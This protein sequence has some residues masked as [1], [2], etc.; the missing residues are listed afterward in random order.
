MRAPHWI[1]HPPN[2]TSSETDL[3]LQMTLTKEQLCKHIYSCI[4]K[5]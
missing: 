1:L 5:W 3:L 4:V 2:K